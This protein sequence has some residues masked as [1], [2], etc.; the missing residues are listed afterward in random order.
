MGV[1]HRS[2]FQTPDMHIAVSRPADKALVFEGRRHLANVKDFVR[3][4][5]R[6]SLAQSES[7]ESPFLKHLIVGVN[8]D[9]FGAI[10]GDA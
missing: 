8:G 4:E 1:N 3:T 2:G 9:D 5:N 10:R 6:G 7:G